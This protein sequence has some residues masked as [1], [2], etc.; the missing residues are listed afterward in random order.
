MFAGC[1]NGDEFHKKF[2]EIDSICDTDPQKAISML[3]SID[4]SSLSESNRHR[5]D[6]LHIK[7]R[8]KAYV[9]HTSDSLILNV[10]DY[11]SN[12]R[13]ERLYPEALYYGGRVYSDMGDFPTALTYFQDALDVIPDNKEF[14]QLKCRT[15][16]QTGRLLDELMLHTQAIPY[17]K[18]AIKIESIL[19]DTLRLVYDELLVSKCYLYKD[20]ISKARFHIENALKHSNSIP[21][22][23]IAWIKVQ[24]TEILLAENKA[25][26]ALVLIREN[27]PLV[28]SLCYNYALA[29]ATS[30]YKTNGILDTTYMYAKELATNNVCDN[31][32]TGYDVLFSNELRNVVPHDT[33]MSY[34]S[35]YKQFVDKYLEKYEADEVTIRH[36]KYN[37]DKHVRER[38][39][40]EI[41]KIWICALSFIA[42]LC[43][44]IAILYYRIISQISNTRMKIALQIV[45]RVQRNMI[46]SDII[47]NAEENGRISDNLDKYK[48]LKALPNYNASDKNTLKK[49]LLAKLESITDYSSNKPII[50]EE[51]QKSNVIKKI[52]TILAKK[53]CIISN[54][55]I[56]KKLEQT[57]ITSCPDF[58]NNLMILSDNKM[59]D[60]EYEVAL[61][62]RAGLQPKNIAILLNRTKSTISDRRTSLTKKIFGS[63]EKNLRLD[64]IIS[65]L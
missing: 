49:E 12:H 29:N 57:I 19:K 59:N 58:K 11:Y 18:E 4:Y 56:L 50:D 28:D 62:I 15:L 17:I 46:I 24:L 36:S 63:S 23:D 52:N 5:Y 6:F 14:L 61:L 44:I 47:M 27:L 40:A 20:S 51:L 31:R 16:S 43:A 22:E 25:D 64:I 39:K 7:T 45:E 65:R 54:P 60:N 35:N 38:K 53:Q 9:K 3:D 13:K 42:I 30:I 10:I 48:S 26:S 32:L 41:E 1:V 37:Y 55:T 34:M 33:L 2:M 8:D 21:S